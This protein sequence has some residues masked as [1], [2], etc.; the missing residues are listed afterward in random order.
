M[1][2]GEAR[3]QLQRKGAMPQSL[4]FGDQMDHLETEARK[5]TG[6]LHSAMEVSSGLP[7]PAGLA[8]YRFTLKTRGG[9]RAL[10]LHVWRR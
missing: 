3:W 8:Q 5:L 10:A 2:I 7:R 6:L 4:P 1:D 9:R